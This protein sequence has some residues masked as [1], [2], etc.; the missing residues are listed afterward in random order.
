MSVIN[1][2]SVYF[3]LI[4]ITQ[5]RRSQNGKGFVILVLD[6]SIESLP[7]SLAEQNAGSAD[8]NIYN[9][10]KGETLHL[11]QPHFFGQSQTVRF[12]RFSWLKGS[13]IDEVTLILGDPGADSGGEGKSKWAE[14]YGTKK[15]KERK[16]P[17]QT[18]SKRSSPF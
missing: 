16:R 4:N 13:L 8:G 5:R 17:D 2:H 1:L 12:N 6:L 7:V 10:Y 15:S 3:E 11:S 14:R 9:T 18:T